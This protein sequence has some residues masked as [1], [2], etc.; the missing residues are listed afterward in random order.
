MLYF[1]KYGMEA[2]QEAVQTE[3][4]HA[5]VCKG[6][7]IARPRGIAR[8]DRV[9]VRVGAARAAATPAATAARVASE[10]FSL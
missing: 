7:G 6:S 4:P 9:R 2:Y 3:K 8:F 1:K 10:K 5:D